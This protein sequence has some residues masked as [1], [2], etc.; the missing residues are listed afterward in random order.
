MPQPV[1]K[2]ALITGA[3]S[4]IGTEFAKILAQKKIDLVIASRNIKKLNEIKKGLE[5]TYGIRVDTI[6]SDLSRPGAAKKLHADCMKRKLDIDLLVNNAGTGL[7]GKLNEQNTDELEAMITLNDLSLTVLCSLFGAQMAKK[8]NGFILNVGSLVSL[9]A[10]PYFAS[11]AASKSYVYNLSI[12]LNRE[13]KKKK[14]H[15]TCLL[16]GY[17]RTQFDKN[18]KVKGKGY[19]AFSEMNTMA[20]DKVAR[21]GLKALFRKKTIVIAGFR[22]K[23]FSIFARLLPKTWT[24]WLMQTSLDAMVKDQ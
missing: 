4:G 10:M 2:R 22:N 18:S 1:V 21:I 23:F 12:A 15:V 24:A 20:P 9:M 14:V 16:P 8:K 5:N 11:Y 6:C 7:F 3:S 19:Q 17:V 13:L